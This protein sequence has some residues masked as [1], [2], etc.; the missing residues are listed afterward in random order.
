VTC[1]SALP[2]DQVVVLVNEWGTAPRLAAGEQNSP[3]PVLGALAE[4]V[5][6]V[7]HEQLTAVA[8][9]VYPIFAAADQDAVVRR[10]NE[11]LDQCEPHP[12]LAR[13][14]GV[15]G[16]AWLTDPP[17]EILS[18]AA[19]GLYRQLLEW[20][21]AR[22]LGTCTAANC[23]DV[24]VDSSSAGQRKFCSVQCQNRS[25]VAAFRARR[26]GT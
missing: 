20:G 7:G 21:D 23:V 1:V 17:R 14:G 6:D 22:R 3:Y 24:Y 19:L 16:E 10:L 13:A 12:R 26:S 25:R 2:L 18:A 9:A 11:V 15:L 5:G 8:D 4:A